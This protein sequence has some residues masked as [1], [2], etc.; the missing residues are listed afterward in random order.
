MEDGRLTLGVV[1][2]QFPEREASDREL[3]RMCI[4]AASLEVECME[5]FKLKGTAAAPFKDSVTGQT[6]RS[7]LVY[8]ARR[9]EMEY[10]VAKNVYR[11]VPREEAFRAQG[12]APISVKWIDVN[13]GATRTQSTDP[14]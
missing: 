2:M 14:G 8:A 5:I 12:K 6:L 1:G 3:E 4:N 10:F 13:K 11:K 9:E 7:E